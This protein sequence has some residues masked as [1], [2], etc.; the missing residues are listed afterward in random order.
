M[1]YECA[2]PSVAYCPGGFLEDTDFFFMPTTW[3]V[4]CKICSFLATDISLLALRRFSNISARLTPSM[5]LRT[6]F[7][8]HLCVLGP[9]I[10]GCLETLSTS[11]S[12]RKFES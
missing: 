11:T 7:E 4:A 5:A 12:L 1:L 9:L 3:G 8:R 2:L 10:V 6:A